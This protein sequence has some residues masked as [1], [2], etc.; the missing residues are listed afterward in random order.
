MEFVNRSTGRRRKS[1]ETST[2]FREICSR[3]NRGFFGRQFREIVKFQEN[4]VP[5]AK[6][7]A[8]FYLKFSVVSHF[9]FKS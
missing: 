8:D 7:G 9:S 3:D 2:Y 4:S 1:Y 6:L 5:F